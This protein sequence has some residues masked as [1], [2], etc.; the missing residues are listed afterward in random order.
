MNLRL[1]NEFL[2][3]LFALLIA[4]IVVHGI[5]VGLIRPTAE[6]QLAV[7]AAL[8][9]AGA[10]M[11]SQRTLAIVIRDFEQEACFILLLWALAIMGMKAYR[12]R[13]EHQMLDQ[14]LIEVPL[15][16]SLLPQ[17]AREYSRN[18]EALPEQEQDYLLPRSL[19]NGLQRF[20]T[21]QSIPAVSE[22]VREQCDIEADRLDSELSMV[23]Y[24]S[25]AI[26]SI[27][28]I[29]TVRGI[30]DALGQ[31][32]KAVEGDISGVTVSLGVAFNSTFVALVLSII[33]MFALHQLQLSQERLVLSTQRYVDRKL[34]RHLAVPTL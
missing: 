11:A 19:M 12:T 15:G 14:N 8:Q 23:R 4:I 30:G 10:D 7:Q 32:Y 5:Y 24:I 25:W 29:G 22:A 6:D 26:P 18:L 13:K 17:D 20:A 1:N 33:I 28:F 34:L 31:A 21:T 27:G 3:Q 9:A 16:T 2:Y